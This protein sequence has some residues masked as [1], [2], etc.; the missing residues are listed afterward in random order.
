[1]IA[2]DLTVYIAGPYSN[3]DPLGVEI[4]VCKAID[5]GEEIEDA[6]LVAFIP[7]LSHFRHQRRPRSYEHWMAADFALLDRCDALLRMP[8]PSKGADR[9]VAFA[10]NRGIPVF[11][12]EAALLTWAGGWKR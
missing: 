4:N 5:A 1:V 2:P 11:N 8:G 12:D 7:H 10:G 9:E 6:G 3:P